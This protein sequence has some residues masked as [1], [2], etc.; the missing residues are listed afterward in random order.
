MT[1]FKTRNTIVTAATGLLFLAACGKGGDPKKG[2]Q[3]QNAPAP[4]TLQEIQLAPTTYYDE[5]PGTTVALSQV[6][7]H[8]QVGGY[9]TGIFF[10]E[11]DHVRKGQKL[12]EIDKSKYLA[13]YTQAQANLAQAKANQDRAQKDADRYIYLNK[14]DAIAK[15]ILDH[16]LT[17]LDNAKSGVSSANAALVSSRTDLNFATIL[18]PFDG[19]IGLSQVKLGT[20]VSPNTTLLATISTDNPVAVDFVVNEQTIPRFTKLNQQ[21]NTDAPGDSLFTIKLADGSLYNA[22]GRISL[23]DRAVDPQTGTLRVRLVF[24]N[25]QGALKAGMS[26]TVRV[27]NQ[28]AKEQIL[29][30]NKATTEQMGEYFVFVAK[31]TVI[32]PQTDSAKKAAKK[33]EKAA[34]T[35]QLVAIQKKVVLGQVIGPNVVVKTGLQPGEKIIVDGMQKLKSGAPVTTAVAPTAPQQGAA[36]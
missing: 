13:S 2:A 34:N 25:A 33:D 28:D 19:T 32:A 12:Y 14:Q 21:R 15:Q 6:D 23:L 10:K 22:P 1:T 35:P 27:H 11:G 5:Y 26:C 7:L 20:D 24:P 8:A 18:A 36:K 9:I 16:A 17:D 3:Q 4:V 31:D 30:P 29:I